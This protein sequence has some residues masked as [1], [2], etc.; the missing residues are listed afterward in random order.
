M[1][2]ADIVATVLVIWTMMKFS[3]G[4]GANIL[5]D[6][7]SRYWIFVYK[8]RRHRTGWLKAKFVVNRCREGLFL[9]ANRFCRR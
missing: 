9:S 6:N 2:A 1:V 4:E 3:G 8:R 7:Y 5:I